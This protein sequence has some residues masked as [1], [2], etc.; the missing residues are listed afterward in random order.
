MKASLSSPD[1]G[2]DTSAPMSAARLDGK[3]SRTAAGLEGKISSKESGLSR[4]RRVYLDAIHSPLRDVGGGVQ[5]AIIG[6]SL[7]VATD[8]MAE[9]Y[10]EPSSRLTR[11]PPT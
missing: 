8:A 9:N 3:V 5:N 11:S 10:Y 4:R 2:A 1:A 6:D 7:S